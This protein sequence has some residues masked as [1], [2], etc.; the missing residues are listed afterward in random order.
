[1]ATDPYRAWRFGLSVSKAI[2]V[3]GFSGTSIVFIFYDITLMIEQ[4]FWSLFN[5]FFHLK[6]LYLVITEPFFWY[7]AGTMIAG[8]I[9]MLLCSRVETPQP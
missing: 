9:G 6:V 4:G 2:S 7:A 5:P 8:G 1:M 3:V